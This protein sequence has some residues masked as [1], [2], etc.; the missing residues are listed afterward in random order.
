MIDIKKLEEKEVVFSNVKPT[1]KEDI[2]FSKFLK[3]RKLKKQRPQNKPKK[4][5]A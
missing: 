4:V 5:K 3:E 2:E 1:E